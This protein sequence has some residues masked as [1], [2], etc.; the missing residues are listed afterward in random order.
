MAMRPNADSIAEPRRR[1]TSSSELASP[2]A[3]STPEACDASVT[4]QESLRAV[5]TQT[6][7]A[8]QATGAPAPGNF[9]PLMA[10]RILA[11]RGKPLTREDRL[12]LQRM[13]STLALSPHLYNHLAFVGDEAE[14]AHPEIAAFH[15]SEAPP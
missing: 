11:M 6:R 14:T 5:R 1:Q 13:D 9:G 15:A 3:P 12:L 8:V 7:S 10:L 4:A 2:P